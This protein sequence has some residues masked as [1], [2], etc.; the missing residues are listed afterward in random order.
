MQPTQSFKSSIA[1]NS[2]F[3]RAADQEMGQQVMSARR[4]ILI[5]GESSLSTHPAANE[6]DLRS[7]SRSRDARRKTEALRRIATEA[8]Y[9][10]C[11]GGRSRGD[12][13]TT[14]A[15]FLQIP[16]GSA[17]FPSHSSLANTSGGV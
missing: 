7:E 5:I 15:E 12:R 4:R 11:S 10:R 3:G 17:C 8:E 6:Q 2:T 14:P 1:M 16:L 13:E 9:Y